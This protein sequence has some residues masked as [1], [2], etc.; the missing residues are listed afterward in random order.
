MKMHEIE[1]QTNNCTEFAKA[2]KGTTFS[3]IGDDKSLRPRP[4][5]RFFARYIDLFFI[6]F[7]L[8]MLLTFIDPFF[9]TQLKNSL[10]RGYFDCL[11]GMIVLFLYVFIEPLF[12]STFGTTL[13]KWILNV[14]L[15]NLSGSKLNFF[16]VFKRGL[17][18]WGSGLGFGIPFI[19]LV[20]LTGSYTQLTQSGVTKWDKNKFLITHGKI[21]ILKII[22]GFL[23]FLSLCLINFTMALYQIHSLNSNKIAE[24]NKNLQLPKLIDNE[25][26]YTSITLVNNT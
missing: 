16:S 22:T 26:E 3:P 21:N 10:G 24:L 15:K 19:S 18:L 20:K 12:L 23:I 8:T 7:L 9:L 25:T 5:I 17:C 6:S 4:W 11:V 2:F 1:N 13:G 14:R